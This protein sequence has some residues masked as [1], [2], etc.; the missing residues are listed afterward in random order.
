VEQQSDTI[1]TTSKSLQRQKRSTWIIAMPQRV[2]DR[3]HHDQGDAKKQFN[4]NYFVENYFATYK[5]RLVNKLD[6]I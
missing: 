3:R 1:T 4:L 2:D 5:K 6:N